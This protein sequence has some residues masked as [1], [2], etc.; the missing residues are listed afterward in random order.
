[1]LSNLG[2]LDRLLDICRFARSQVFESVEMGRRAQIESALQMDQQQ[3]ESL[4]EELCQG[5]WCQEA[6]FQTLLTSC[7]LGLAACAV[8]KSVLWDFGGLSSY[9]EAEGALL[10]A[11]SLYQES[12]D[13]LRGAAQDLQVFA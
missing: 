6:A 8:I 12:L 1:M 5:N 11:R 9:R 3:L 10:E 4:Y 7:E 2:V 13:C